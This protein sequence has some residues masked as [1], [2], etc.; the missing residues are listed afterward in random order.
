[1]NKKTNSSLNEEQKKAAYC[2]ENAVIT[3]GAG[4]G[5]TRVLAN[6]FA[7]LLTKKNYKIN[8]ILTLTFT[9]KAAVEMNKRIF[10]MISDIAENESGV[11]AQRAS[12]ALDDF[13]HARIQTLD[14]YGASIVKQ[15]APRY[16]IS[17][18]FRIDEDRCR[19][20]AQEIS[21]PY[22]ISLRNHP[23]VEKLYSDNHPDVI[24]NNIFADILFKYSQI[25]KP[26]DFIQDVKSQF[27]TLCA[28]W[29]NQNE[30][31]KSLLDEI[32]RDS[33]ENESLY[34]P[35]IPVMQ[36]YKKENIEIPSQSCVRM[37]LDSLFES[38]LDSV[39][40][41]AENHPLQNQITVYLYFLRS[42]RKL[43][44]R[45][46]KQKDNP[47]KDNL[48]IIRNLFDGPVLP[49]AISCMQAGFVISI[50]SLLMKLQ[51]DYLAK[52]RAESILTF[53][54]VASLSR[55]ILLE[56]K[57]IRQSEKEA[58]KSIMI[59]EFQDNNELQKDIL[60][61]IAEKSEKSNDIIP[62]VD[63]LYPDKL[64]FV[65]DEKQSIYFFRGADVSVFRRLKEEIKSKDLPLK[66]NYRS[67]PVLIGAFNAIFGGSVYDP[68][69]E[70][71]SH[72]DSS[73]FAPPKLPPYEAEYTP[74]Q[75][76]SDNN[77]SLSIC[78]LNK[79]AQTDED[80]TRL[81]FYENEARFTAEKIKSLL[82]GTAGK[83]YQP[84]DIA[85]LLRDSAPQNMFEKHLRAFDIPY[86]CEKIN[87]LFFDG[88]VND[89]LS[90]LR[91]ASYP[92][93]EAAYA[94]M[95]RS[96]FAGLSLSG[97]AL[98]LSFFHEKENTPEPFDDKPL[99]FLEAADKECYLNGREI[100]F[101]IRDNCK[102]KS[103][104]ALVSKLWYE[105]GYRYE[106]E[107]NLQ[108]SAYR[109]M[110]DYLFHLAAKADSDN[111]GL[112]SFTDSMI[113]LRDSR[114][115][116]SSDTAIPLERP[117][118]VSIMT[119]HKSKGL[120]FPV[121]FLC[122]CGKR[123]QSD[124]CDVVFNSETAGIVFSPPAP[125]EC[126][127]IS[128]KKNNFFWELASEEIKRKRTAE[129]RRLLYVGMTRAEN[130]LY[131]TGSIDIKENDEINDFSLL[132][133]NDIELKITK[134]ENYIDGDSILD[135]DT[136]FGILLPAI[137]SHIPEDGYKKNKSFFNLEEIPAL[138]EEDLR[139]QVSVSAGFSNDQKGLKQYI[140]MIEPFYEKT[141]KITTPI[142]KT[143]HITPVQLKDSEEGKHE[144][145][146][147]NLIDKNF[148]GIN[149]NDIFKKVDSLLERFSKNDDETNRKFNS[150]NFGTIAH[151]CVEAL[152]NGEEAIIPSNIAGL[153]T[154]TEY[155]TL[156]EAGN[157]LAARFIGSPLGNAAKNSTL[158]ENEFPF[159]SIIK[160][161][162]GKEI[163]INGTIDLFFEDCDF[164]HVVDFKTDNIENTDE[165]TA[166]M[167]CYYQA[168][169][170]LFAK[171]LKKQ[172]KVW[173]YYLR[174]GHA[175]E[176][177]EKVNRFNLEKRAFN[178]L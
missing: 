146:C 101:S 18:D 128:A 117:S 70:E 41:I 69:G 2:T 34:L 52:K 46:G 32:D 157:E 83:K 153:V 103:V 43:D 141:E 88:P 120:E 173:L 95:L 133:K 90:V 30:K 108:T 65:G 17:P 22:F 40:E 73:V 68:K 135:N 35:I 96:P 39:V 26:R 162:N 115:Q 121:V 81:S 85:I 25:D 42:L 143:N 31:I 113:A 110:Y 136:L 112:A 93:D 165:H 75:A 161:D 38:P 129:L 170:S 1:M 47:V 107:W 100:Y 138:T 16:G 104:S 159:R 29:K 167:S 163:F 87:N 54:D 97:A 44:M 154:V 144:T 89:I 132:L 148:S 3:A 176:M 124:R 91:L 168:I 62:P 94:E 127:S 67:S 99:D 175:V 137:V 142:I 53:H 11:K 37:Y 125:L 126:R 92:M 174:T 116:L 109:E 139:N 59:D 106:T 78:V 156:L 63:D 51:K 84:S 55:T 72:Q 158:R 15:C 82:L 76:G 13:I 123:G 79:K 27:N 23:A 12:Q 61:L 14:S 58:F 98:C 171:S 134:K 105:D 131:I 152:L 48:K 56:Q 28:E 172:C 45:S 118:A 155:Q 102:K 60:F 33:S 178:M 130:E 9:K 169:S 140:K 177:T 80:D 77:G 36:K 24:V 66:I 7:W 111:Q 147:N 151:A 166:Q 50:M 64:F 57:D 5:K 150:A 4:S 74:L 19:E 160:N 119:I 86:T 164:I 10:S 145:A 149:S 71:A 8:E 21:Y 122:C 6:R 114:R 20:L 49:L